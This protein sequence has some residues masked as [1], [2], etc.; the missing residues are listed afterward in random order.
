[1]R[2]YKITE[3]GPVDSHQISEVPEPPAEAGHVVIKVRAI[4]L[5]YPDALMLQGK[6]QKKPALPFIPGRDLAGDIIAV[7]PGV[8]AFKVG[9]RVVAQVFS[10]AFAEVVS[11]PLQRV[12]K[13]PDALSYD[14]AAGGITVFNTAYVAVVFRAAVTAGE[15]VLITGAAGGVGLAA[16]QLCAML[17]AKVTAVVSSEEKADLCRANG[18]AEI[19]LSTDDSPEGLKA[20]FQGVTTRVTGEAGYEVVIDTVGGDAFNASLRVLGFAGRM[21]VVGFASGRISETRLHYVLYNNLAILGAPLDIHFEK[22]LKRMHAA[23]GHWTTLMARGAISANVTEVHSFDKIGDVFKRM[24]DRKTK[25][26]IVL[27]LGA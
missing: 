3:Y 15:N 8:E 7:G 11:A 26:K 6:Y 18:A 25:G 2:A 5:N 1:M 9:D 24:L 4:G 22:E 23:V 17:G 27:S 16:V 12:F 21:V 20:A 19:L 13:L 10:G 14:D